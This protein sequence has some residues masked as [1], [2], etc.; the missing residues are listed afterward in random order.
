MSIRDEKLKSI[1][2]QLSAEFLNR[3][4]TPQSLITVMDCEL[5]DDSKRAKIIVS[6][7]PPDQGKTAL[8]FLKR[9][10]SDLHNH[11]EKNL[12]AGRIPLVDFALASGDKW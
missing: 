9:Q 4:A 11:L 5:E 6:V 8:A 1:L 10:R 12:R 3:H 2:I 7:F